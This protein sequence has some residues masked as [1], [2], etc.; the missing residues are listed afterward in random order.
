M[1]KTDVLFSNDFVCNNDE[2]VKLVKPV[3]LC[4]DIPGPSKTC[5]VASK[6]KKNK[7]KKLKPVKFVKE[8]ECSYEP[9][10]STKTCSCSCACNKPSESGPN[11]STFHLK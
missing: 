5:N 7:I 9:K 3:L 2:T 11:S 1:L 4:T 6:P 10:P 8:G